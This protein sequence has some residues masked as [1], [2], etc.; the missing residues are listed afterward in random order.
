MSRTQRVIVLIAGVLISLRLF[1]PAVMLHWND[2]WHLDRTGPA[3]CK[4]GEYT[5][6]GQDCWINWRERGI[7]FVPLK[8]SEALLQAVAV[9]VLAGGL[10]LVTRKP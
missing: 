7:N 6:G 4:A 9:A 2:E 10:L 3:P 1:F 5:Y 8:P